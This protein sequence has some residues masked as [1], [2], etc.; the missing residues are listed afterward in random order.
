MQVPCQGERVHTPLSLAYLPTMPRAQVQTRLAK[1][2]ADVQALVMADVAGQV[3]DKGLRIG[4]HFI[5]GGGAVVS[6]GVYVVE[7]ECF[8]ERRN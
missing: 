8:G 2:Y 7:R 1:L 5:P 6:I 3:A 4:S